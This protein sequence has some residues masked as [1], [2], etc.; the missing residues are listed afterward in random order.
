[1]LDILKKENVFVPL[2]SPYNI[3]FIDKNL[4]QLKIAPVIPYS[5]SLYDT[6]ENMY[7]KEKLT[8]KFEGKNFG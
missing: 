3:F 4:K 6:T 5:S 2:Y 7:L 8:M 1:M